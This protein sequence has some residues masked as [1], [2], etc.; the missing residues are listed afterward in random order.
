MQSVHGKLIYTGKDVVKDAYVVF[1]QTKV[2]S[3]SKKPRGKVVGKY[4]VITPAFI[5][6]HS[7]IGMVRAG[8]P[9]NEGETNE[10]LDMIM[11]VPDALDSILMDDGG[12]VESMEAGVLYSCVVPGS[13]QVIGGRSAFIRNYGRNTTEALVARVGLKGAMGFNPSR[14]KSKPGQRPGTR[15]G[16]LSLLRKRLHAVR[17]KMEKYR[18]A[19][20]KKK[21]E[22]T[23]D[24]EEGVLRDVLTGKE[25]L[26]MHVHKI[27][28]V[29]ALLRL[30]DEFKLK[31]TVE[32]TCDV[33]DAHIYEEL[34]R[35]KIPVIYGPL[36]S[37]AY[38]VELKHETWRNIRHLIDSG[39]QFGLMTD[40]P[41]IMQKTLLMTL[42][43]FLRC[44]MTKQ[45][46]VELITRHNAE[47]LGVDDRLGTLSRGKWASFVGWTGD[48]FDLANHAAAA[49]GEGKVVCAE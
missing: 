10:Q 15:M 2:V 30:V 22:I 26:R 33:H 4:A 3:V 31:L 1:N 29:A 36:D 28:D 25:R 11:P 40:H 8:E 23:F 18:K 46:A 42:R 47:V 45:Q 32:H 9:S 14:D 17:Q 19:R 41:V 24:A 49:W 12:F 38:K 48:P 7:H 43:H 39:V 16:A 37:L 5:D 20:G 13:G 21:D 34:K 35:R 27:D 6:A 44:G